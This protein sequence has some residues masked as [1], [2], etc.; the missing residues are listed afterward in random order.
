MIDT[1]DKTL[2]TI[3]GKLYREKQ[4]NLF[5]L[6]YFDDKLYYS[7]IMSNDFKSNSNELRLLVICGYCIRLFLSIDMRD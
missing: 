3:E 6:I 7:V 4:N 2:V 1:N 5:G